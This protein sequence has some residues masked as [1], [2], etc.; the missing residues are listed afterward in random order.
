MGVTK[1]LC[2]LVCQI[3]LYAG[4][5]IWGEKGEKKIVLENGQTVFRTVDKIFGRANEG[6]EGLGEVC[7]GRKRLLSL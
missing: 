7:E 5:L 2:T 3:D 4:L 6:C 1:Q